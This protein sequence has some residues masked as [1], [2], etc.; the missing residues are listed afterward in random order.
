MVVWCTVASLLRL[1]K[2]HA[3]VC[4]CVC[5]RQHSRGAR[6]HEHGARDRPR[7]QVVCGRCVAGLGGQNPNLE[8]MLQ[9]AEGMRAA[10]LPDWFQLVGLLHDMG[11]IMCVWMGGGE[12]GGWAVKWEL[13]RVMR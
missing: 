2:A 9:T 3:T 6:P 5:V 10:G 13:A 12:V 1:C 11:K 4:V 7:S 8:H